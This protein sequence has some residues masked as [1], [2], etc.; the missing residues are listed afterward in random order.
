M[1]LRLA[2]KYD[3]AMVETRSE[4]SRNGGTATAFT[5][6]AA[7]RLRQAVMMGK[8]ERSVE[9]HIPA[10][11]RYA[12]ALLRD[13]DRAEDLLQ[14]SLER[15]LS[16]PHLFVRPDN[17]RGWLF[18]IMRN[19]YLNSLRAASRAPPALALENAS[20]PTV[21]PDQIP[22]VEVAETLAA[23]DRLPDEC[24]EALGLIVVEGVSYRE[25]GRILG[26]PCGAV[27]SRVAHAREELRIRCNHVPNGHLRRVK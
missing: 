14:D 11:R 3:Y 25:A 10:L 6:A 18:R 23:F 7:E 4:E 17:L 27:V 19:V 2:S 15:A 26:I 16:R 1:L 5:G 9:S 24:R 12:R 13:A 8:F 21:P 22:R 20:L